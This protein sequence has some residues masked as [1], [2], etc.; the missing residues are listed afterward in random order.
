MKPSLQ[1]E[2]Y[3]KN[4]GFGA[5]ELANVEAAFVLFLL[6]LLTG[7]ALLGGFF[8]WIAR[9]ECRRLP[10]ATQ[11]LMEETRED[12]PAQLKQSPSGLSVAPNESHAPWEQ[13]PDW[14]KNQA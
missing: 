13:D 10:E 6:G 1:A 12:E 2:M 8:V 5:S 11:D 14:W 7:L 4:F 3:G 9:R